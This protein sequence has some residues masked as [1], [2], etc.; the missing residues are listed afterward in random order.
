MRSLT[1]GALL[2]LLSL[3]TISA[4]KSGDFKTCSQSAFCR[5]GRA[6]AVR[7]SENAGIW[8]SP[9]SLDSSSITI[10]ADQASFTAGVNSELYPDVKFEL[11]VR[12]HDDG[13]VRVRMDEREGL[14]KRYDEA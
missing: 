9:Y 4:V 10:A 3:P 14:F 5:R 6:L 13:V 11:D 8:K 12:I 1:A 2:L 7:A